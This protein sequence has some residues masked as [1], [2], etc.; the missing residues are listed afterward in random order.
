FSRGDKLYVAGNDT[1]SGDHTSVENEHVFDT[2]WTGITSVTKASTVSQHANNAS[3]GV[4]PKSSAKQIE[5][6]KTEL[7]GTT[8]M[9]IAG[10]RRFTE[11]FP[12][13]SHIFYDFAAQHDSKSSGQSTIMISS[14]SGQKVLAKC[15]QAQIHR[16][17]VFIDK[18]KNAAEFDHKDVSQND[19]YSCQRFYE[20]KSHRPE[21]NSIVQKAFSDHLLSSWSANSDCSSPLWNLQ[22]IWG[23]PKASDFENLMVFQKISRFRGTRGLTR[24]DL[25]KKNIQRFTSVFS[26]AAGGL[27]E[28]TDDSFNIMPLTYALPHEYNSFVSGY[29][30]IQKFSGEKSMNNWILKPIGMSRGRGISVVSDIEDVSYSQP[31]VIQRYISDPFLFLGFKFDLRIYVLVTSFAPIE[32]FIYKEGFARFGS[33]SYSSRPESLHDNRIH[34]TNTSI[35]KEFIGDIDRSHPAYL[36]GSNGGDSKVTVSWLW[37]RL[38]E[39]GINTD[40][41]WQKIIQV[42]TT[43]LAALG[44]DIQNQPNSFELFGFDVIFDQR[45]KCWLIEVNSSP[46]LTCDSSLDTRV[47]GGL[48]RDTI[49]LVD[50][51][52]FDRKALEDICKRRLTH[53]KTAC[54]KSSIDVL[55]H[56]LSQILVGQIPRKYGELPRNIGNFQRI[57]PG[58]PSFDRLNA[59][60]NSQ[61]SKQPHSMNKRQR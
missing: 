20:I 14:D 37:K 48:I 61:K 8:Q 46:S 22:W 56:D 5:D 39:I 38:N 31:I 26:A 33:R 42:C 15:M 59:L 11:L 41:L 7:Q 9:Q 45:L 60:L 58:S 52:I 24:K 2:S 1:S 18:S 12:T 21:V 47:K 44:S 10:S 34:L 4:S 17:N 40:L 53:R 13:F 23:L 30:S 25:L 54:N 43:A 16:C 19:T 49:A 35:Q 57:A 32:A 29:S 3:F 28:K 51:P 36:A 6:A 50:P 55:E 27:G